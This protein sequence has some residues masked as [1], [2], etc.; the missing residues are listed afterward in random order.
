MA[1][2]VV[3]DYTEIFDCD[4]T[5]INRF[6]LG[7]VNNSNAVDT[8][9]KVEGT[10]SLRARVTGTGVGGNGFDTQTANKDLTPD[11]HI[12][13]WG[14]S[15]D[16]VVAANGWLIRYSTDTDAAANFADISAGNAST[17]KYVVS[18]F[19]NFCVDPLQPAVTENGTVPALTAV[20]SFVILADHL[21]S[22]GRDTF[23]WDQ[24]KFGN[25]I[26]I[27]GGASAPRGSVEVA[28]ADVTA[29]RGA[30]K[31]I[32]GIMYLLGTITLGD[33]TASTNS[34]FEDT[35][36][37]WV[38]EAQNVSASFHRI[39]LVGGTGTNAATWGT[40]SGSGKTAEGSGGNVFIASGLAPFR[41]EC[42]DSDINVGF[43]GCVFINPIALRE[44][45]MRSFKFEDSGTGFTSDTRDANDSNA[46]DAPLLPVT[47][48]LNDASY[49]GDFCGI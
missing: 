17:V 14:R 15:L 7:G 1:V 18:G 24:C 36:Q 13:M 35:A 10:G 20:R 39:E 9:I 16:P 40:K 22:S 11:K 23:F 46:A 27:T 19:F 38:F 42:I 43:F 47:P 8:D 4:T 21:T 30:F 6:G 34:T 2:T 44:D 3:D 26:T 45:A 31:N 29:G 12:F 41:I 5:N 37:V 28:A 32:S 48:A 49:F 33:V 25:G